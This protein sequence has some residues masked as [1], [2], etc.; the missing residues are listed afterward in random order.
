[1]LDD[2]AMVVDSGEFAP[3]R[4]HVGDAGADLRAAT[5]VLIQPGE[6][7]RVGLGVRMAIPHHY[8]G[9]LFARSGLAMKH[10]VWMAN[11]V[12]VIDSQ[13][14]GEVAALLHNGGGE[15]Y[16]VRR[17]DRVAQLVVLYVELPLFRPVSALY[18]SRRGEAGFGST[19]T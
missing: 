2:I 18:E 5:D 14:R 7:K 15:P 10:S 6:T 8:A 16:Q 13:Y 12:G 1:M 17:G 9:F 3:C 19:G 11:G 4:A